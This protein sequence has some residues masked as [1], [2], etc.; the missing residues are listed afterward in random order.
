VFL[1]MAEVVLS[2]GT[3]VGEREKWMRLMLEHV[4]AILDAPGK[5]SRL[6]ETSPLGVPSGH[7]WYLNCIVLG[8]YNGTP[9]ELLEQCFRI[10]RE[11][12]RTHKGLLKPRTADID[13]LLFN[14]LIISEERLQVPHPAILQRRFC[15][16]GLAEVAPRMRHPMVE[17]TFE[18]LLA[19]MPQDVADQE[20][21]FR[22]R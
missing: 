19:A 21:L 16:E 6:M 14:D 20:I 7:G 2:L 4:G 8:E 15:L 17:R 13:I 10:E 12:G 1:L 11:L 5:H 22:T 9:L 3:N 18:E